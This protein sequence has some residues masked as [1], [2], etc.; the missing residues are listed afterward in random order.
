M[1]NPYI[2]LRGLRQVDHTVFCVS[3][4]Q[5]VY[6]DPA[7]GRPQPYSSGQQVKRSVMDVIVTAMEEARAPI[8]FNFKLAGKEGK[9]ELSNEEPWSPCDPSYVDQLIGGWM[10]A[11]KGAAPVKRRSPMSISAMR[12]LH[13]SLASLASE[14]VT[15]DRSDESEQ[16]IARVVDEKG[17]E[18][19]RETVA[20]FLAESGRNLPMRL[21]IPED[22]V[23]GRATGLFIFDAAIDLTS[24]FSVS[25][26]DYEP[27]ITPDIRTK[28]DDHGWTLSGDGKRLICPSARRDAIAGALAEGLI[29]WRITSNQSRTLSLQ[30]TLAVAIGENAN[31]VGTAIRADLTEAS[32]G[33]KAEAVID[34]SAGA[35]VYTAKTALGW[36]RGAT[37]SAD[38]LEAAKADLK[39]RILAHNY[40]I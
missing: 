24:L 20:A 36:V 10:R 27:E 34:D 7:T 13:P 31:A 15:F 21:W 11:G 23:G 38:A 33:Q 6:R 30:N 16:H 22:K 19:A 35:S 29:E 1:R 37:A 2:Y 12:P 26:Y 9:K 4:G 5:K 14:S 3:A 39:G 28:L 18:L 40:E 17:A 8:T 25:L 32:E